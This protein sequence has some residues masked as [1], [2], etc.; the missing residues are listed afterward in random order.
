MRKGNGKIGNFMS[1]AD[2]RYGGGKEDKPS[3]HNSSPNPALPQP[4]TITY[5]IRNNRI[6]PDPYH[7]N[8]NDEVSQAKLRI[9]KAREENLALKRMIVEKS[10]QNNHQ[11]YNPAPSSNQIP[12][13]IPSHSFPQSGYPQQES[14]SNLSHS[15]PPHHESPHSRSHHEDHQNPAKRNPSP[16]PTESMSHPARSRPTS[17]HSLSN[18]TSSDLPIHPPSHEDLDSQS[19]HRSS[20]SLPPK[21]KVKNQNQKKIDKEKQKERIEKRKLQKEKQS[22]Q[23]NLLEHSIADLKRFSN[24]LDAAIDDNKKLLQGDLPILLN[25]SNN[26]SMKMTEAEREAKKKLKLEEKQRRQKLKLQMDSLLRGQVL[27]ILPRW[28][29]RLRGNWNPKPEEILKGKSLFRVGYLMVMYFY[30]KPRRAIQH[31]KAQ[32]KASEMDSFLKSLLLLIDNMGHWIGKLVKLPISS[33][34]QV[35]PSPQTLLPPPISLIHLSLDRTTRLISNQS[36]KLIG[37]L[38]LGHTQP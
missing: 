35:L 19:A 15:P 20:I 9:A 17:N 37:F 13:Q 1:W 21:P 2:S 22:E 26:K 6:F 24:H 5:D 10:I 31:R 12:S 7:Q 25:Q 23:R 38:T 16:V 8:Q 28:R 30:I 14:R 27:N 34:I 18:Q 32:T 4:S 36:E 29:H 11:N 33:I 3:S